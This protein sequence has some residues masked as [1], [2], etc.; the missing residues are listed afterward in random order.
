MANKMTRPPATPQANP[1]ALPPPNH[2]PAQPLSITY[3]PLSP[4][5]ASVARIAHG[6]C[7][8]SCWRSNLTS[9]R[10]SSNIFLRTAR[11]RWECL[12]SF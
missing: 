8:P 5:V 6:R 3:Q 7:S 4:T 10:Q 2:R 1:G 9:V 11:L 12:P